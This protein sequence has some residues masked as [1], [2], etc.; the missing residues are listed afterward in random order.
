MTWTPRDESISLVEQAMQLQGLS[1]DQAVGGA[2]GNLTDPN[3]GLPYVTNT[4]GG[5]MQYPDAE[6][7]GGAL[8]GPGTPTPYPAGT[9]VLPYGGLNYSGASVWGNVLKFSKNLWPYILGAVGGYQVADEFGGGGGSPMGV[10][11]YAG[12]PAIYGS[13]SPVPLGGP[14]LPEP[15]AWMVAKEWKVNGAQFYKLIDGRIAVYSIKKKTWK[16]YRPPKHIVISK[17]PRANDLIKADKKIDALMGR[18]AKRAGLVKR[19]S[20]KKK[21]RVAVP[22]GM[23]IINVD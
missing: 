12:G 15:P 1:P 3:T 19:G 7:Q 10:A 21:T 13:G 23:Q 20:S 18:L 2:P 14:G 17:N 8:I 9:T 4:G 16:V 22:Q 5:N 6:I 11:P